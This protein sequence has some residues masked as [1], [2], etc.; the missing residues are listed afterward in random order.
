MDQFENI[1]EASAVGRLESLV[2]QQL[3]SKSYDFQVNK[4][5]LKSYQVNAE[6]CKPDVICNVLILALMRLPSSNFMSLVF[7]VPPKLLNDNK[8]S[9]VFVCAELLERGKYTEFWEEYINA[10]NVF[11]AA[12]GFVDAIRKI[13]LS[14]LRSTFVAVPKSLFA[15]QLGLNDTDVEPFCQNKF[16]DKVSLICLIFTKALYLYANFCRLSERM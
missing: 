11:K 1:Y 10:Q 8:I 5:L 9:L 12:V 7:L 14:N 15:Q 3:Q 2:N 6:V 13:I 4:S 16:V